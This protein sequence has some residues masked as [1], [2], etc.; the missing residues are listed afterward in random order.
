MEED[1]AS[2]VDSDGILIEKSTPF[3][4]TSI[5]IRHVLEKSAVA[6]RSL[7]LAGHGEADSVAR[8]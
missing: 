1:T 7:I 6:L 4:S 2:S 3:M 8:R 5:T